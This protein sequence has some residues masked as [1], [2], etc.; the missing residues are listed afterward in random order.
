[1]AA[2]RGNRA[3][4]PDLQLSAVERVRRTMERLGPTCAKIGQMLS[5]RPDLIPP[6]FA[7]ELTKLQDEMAPFP[8]E[9]AREEIEAE[10]GQSLS[11]LFSAFDETPAAAASIGQVHFATLRDGTEVAVKVQRPGIR[12][13]IEADLDIL[14]TQARR[15]HGRTDLGKRYDVVGLVDEFA[16]VLHEE[17]DYVQE[18]ENA[19]RLA[20]AFE[21]D[22]TVHFPAVHWELTSATVLTMELIDGIPFNRLETLDAEGVNRHEIARRG[23]TCYYEQIFIHGFYHADP[24][25]GNLFA[26]PDGR[27][28]FTDFGRTGTLS[29]DARGHVADLLVA[30]IDQDG[31]AAGDILMEVSQGVADVD[32]VGL[33]RDV[34]NLIIKYYDLRLHEVDTRELVVEIMSLIGRRGLNLQS[35]YALLLT[36]LATIQALGS[37]VDPEFHFVESVTPFARRIIEEQMAPPA[38]SR[39]FLSTFRRT[40]RAMR[41]LPDNVN[42]AIKRVGDGDLRMTVRPGGY[43]PLMSR[44]EQT[45]DRL[46]FAVVVSAFVIACAWLLSSDIPMWLEVIA[47]LVLVGSFGVGVSFFLSTVFRRWR[48]RRHED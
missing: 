16:R 36:T 43:D 13:I 39:N 44:I 29:D 19:Q 33:K 45:V 6:S 37:S 15:I 9:Q 31:D 34:T 10:F 28:A 22:E 46:A 48:Q 20:D 21:G 32:A 40:L 8:F 27:V 2:L 35:E 7:A 14:R 4:N 1:L 24:H 38:L 47:G 25:P 18:G 12:E 42:R 26:M 30:I 3:Y 5:V 23:I 11:E 41:G 17:C